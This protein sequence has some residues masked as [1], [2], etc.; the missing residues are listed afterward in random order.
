MKKRKEPEKISAILGSFLQDKG[1]ASICK[2]YEVVAQ[3]GSI[4]GERI[5]NET[6]CT[7]AENGKLYVK[8]FSASW[9]QELVYLKE[10]LLDSIRQK[11]GCTSIKEIN[12][13]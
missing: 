3:W 7:R 8:V 13:Y 6:E 4:A 2:E 9:R 11:T 10:Q 1:Y 5:A 12:F